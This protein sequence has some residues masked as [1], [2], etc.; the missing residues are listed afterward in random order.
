MRK[1]QKGQ[2]YLKLAGISILFLLFFVLNRTDIETPTA[3]AQ[4]PTI[5][6]GRTLLGGWRL[7]EDFTRGAIA[8]DFSRNKLWMVSHPYEKEILEY[9]LPAMGTGDPG[10]NFGNWPYVSPVRTIPQWWPNCANASFETYA[11]GLIF[12]RD[13][14]WVSPRDFYAQ[15]ECAGKPLTLYAEDGETMAFPTLSQQGFTGFVKRGPGLDP[16]L[17]GAGYTSGQGSTHGPS[18]AT[19]DGTARISY[20][21]L[22]DPG[23]NLEY[24]DRR[25]PRPANYWPVGGMNPIDPNYQIRTGVDSWVAWQ[26]RLING[27]M[28]GRWG[29]DTIN[30]GGLSLPEGIVYWPTLGLNELDY[31]CQCLGFSWTGNDIYTYRYDPS[32]YQFLDYTR[33]PV[34]P[35]NPAGNQ[36]IGGQ[37][38]DAQGRIYLALTNAHYSYYKVDVAIL[39]FSAPNGANPP[40]PPPPPPAPTPTPPP[41]PPTGTPVP[42]DIN[43]DRIVNSID[44]SILNSDW[45]TSNSR[46]DLNNDGIVNAIDYSILNAN[47]FRTW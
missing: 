21:F 1:R 36:Q 22:A 6:N 5:L 14:L 25:A 27:V 46:S 4:T 17:G 16:L 34:Q 3:Q 43:L 42:G 7:S 47:W 28:E 24:W 31:A 12:W 13:K 18:L 29:V 9:D 32:T 38:I 20:G 2:K 35:D 10:T 23:P 45:F 26:P 11:H 15:N 40:P 30:G 37:E 8:M 39:V 19:L 44:Y 41:P 33:F